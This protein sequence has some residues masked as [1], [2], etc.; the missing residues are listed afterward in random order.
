[1]KVATFTPAKSVLLA[2]KGVHLYTAAYRFN[3]QPA[4]WL[5][6]VLIVSPTDTPA[7]DE[8]L[9]PLIPHGSHIGL[10]RTRVVLSV[11]VLQLFKVSEKGVFGSHPWLK[12]HFPDPAEHPSWGVF[13]VSPRY[14]YKLKF[15][16]LSRDT[17]TIGE[18]SGFDSTIWCLVEG[19]YEPF[20]WWKDKSLKT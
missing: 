4:S 10:L 15:W 8:S 11:V 5:P 19:S 3:L 20:Y 6:S 14:L 16:G 2:A 18:G 13:C 1:M 12:W 9:H 17:W 7:G